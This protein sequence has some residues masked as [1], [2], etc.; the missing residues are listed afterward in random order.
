MKNSP[1]R[2]PEGFLW[3]G[4]VAANQ[5]E[6]A[7]NV[8][9]KGAS[10]ADHI[11]AGTKSSPRRFTKEIRNGESYPSHE[12]IDFYHNYKKDIA[13]LGEMG[14][15]VFRL[16]IA[17]S[18][19]FPNGDEKEPNQAGLAFYRNVFTECKKYGMEPLVTLSHYEMPYHLCEVYGGWT[20]RKVI[21]FFLHYCE[22]VFTEYRELVTH[23]LTFNE[24]N[25]LVSRFG[26]VLCAGILPEDGEDLFGMIE[27]MRSR[28]T[29]GQE[30]FLTKNN[31]SINFSFK[32]GYKSINTQK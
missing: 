25:T 18:R 26:N 6:G 20:S 10:I 13:L 2:F 12:A 19:I 17:W 21:D 23:W 8:D 28:Y 30:E 16:S 9:G 27:F 14:F 3:G 5:I 22:T 1:K 15:K 11:T 32:W 4:A 29:A 24:M 31:L 7:W